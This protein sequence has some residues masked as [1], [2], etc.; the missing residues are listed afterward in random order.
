MI[1]QVNGI[2]K[3]MHQ[4]SPKVQAPLQPMAV[5]H[6][7]I[8]MHR[9]GSNG[10][11]ADI[12]KTF[13]FSA[14]NSPQ[15]SFYYHMFGATMGSLAVEVNTGGGWTSLWSISGQQQIAEEA[16]WIQNT[17]RFGSLCGRSELSN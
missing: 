8:L 14:Y 12:A 9:G 16:A 6:M 1:L 2:L 17:I 11:T 10:Q 15:I 7:P 5:V 4:L 3:K 13:D